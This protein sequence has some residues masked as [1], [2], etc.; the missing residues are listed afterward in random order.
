MSRFFLYIAFFSLLSISA[1]S[2]E[3]IRNKTTMLMGSRF[4]I[5]VVAKDESTADGFIS[6]AENEITR[7]ENLISSWKNDSEI[8]QVNLHAGVKP[9]QVSKE[10]FELV[11]RAL[12]ISELTDGAFDI[13]YASMD[14]IWKFDGTMDGKMPT[15]EMIEKSISKVGYKKIILDHKKST[16]YLPEKGMKIGF[17]AIGKGYAADKAKALMISNGV[18][19]GIINASGD[20]STWG[21]QPDGSDWVVGITNPVNKEKMFSWLPIVDRAIATSGNYEKKIVI[22]GREY[23]HIIDPRSG[24]PVGEISSVSI[25]TPSA[26]MCDALATSVFVLGVEEGLFLINQL[27][28]VD[29]L[30][31]DQNREIHLSKQLKLQNQ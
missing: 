20:L 2:Q 5:T 12:L 23:S 28:G 13:S 1:Q 9:V 19:A 18:E 6:I 4:D 29:C 11:Q 10:V 24:F 25:I 31:V 26:E 14:R 21:K 3:I 7:I 22:E 27:D 17:G 30:I 8:G 16:I 15:Q